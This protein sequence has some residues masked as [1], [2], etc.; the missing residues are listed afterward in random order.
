MDS[1]YKLKALERG[2]KKGLRYGTKDSLTMINQSAKFMLL[3]RVDSVL[4]TP[5]ATRFHELLICH[6]YS[7]KHSS[8]Y[9]ENSPLRRSSFLSLS[10]HILLNQQNSMLLRKVQ[11]KKKK[12]KKRKETNSSHIVHKTAYYPNKKRALN[13]Q[14]P[15]VSFPDDCRIWFLTRDFKLPSFVS[16]GDAKVR[17]SLSLYWV[18]FS[19]FTIFASQN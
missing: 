3:Y 5:A 19:L 15:S 18:I 17:S 12:K 4:S 13:E 2:E 16:F 14:P 8:T 10:R 7:Q 6:C 1:W 11:K 9:Q